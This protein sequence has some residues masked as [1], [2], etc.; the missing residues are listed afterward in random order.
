VTQ[1]HGITNEMVSDAPEF[2]E[3]V[4][5]IVELFGN[6][7]LV[8][9]NADFDEAILN[10][11]FSRA[12]SSKRVSVDCAMKAYANGG[13]WSKLTDALAECGITWHGDAH[14]AIVDTRMTLKLLRYMYQNS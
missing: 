4:A 11:E 12:G 8:A 14:D 9:Y 5:S 3:V 10:A 2:S 6:K 13:R 7:K 1:I